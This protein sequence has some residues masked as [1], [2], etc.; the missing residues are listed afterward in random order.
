MMTAS[1]LPAP[2][3]RRYITLDHW[4]GLAC[5]VVLINHSVWAGRDSATWSDAER[6]IVAV[7]SELWLGVP[8]FFVI[9]GYCISAT[10]DAHRRREHNQLSSYMWRRVRRIFPPYWVVLAAVVLLVGVV[11]VVVPRYPLTIGSG[12]FLRPWW[13]SPAQ[14]LGNVTL[15]EQWRTNVTGGQK[16]WFLGHAWTLAYEE[17]FYLVAALLLWL[18]PRRFFAGAAGVSALVGVTTLLSQRHGWTIQ[19]FFL[20]GSWLQFYLGILVYYSLNYGSSRLR[21]VLVAS[22]GAI[23]GT[24]AWS[25][26]QVLSGGKAEAD[27]FFVALCFAMILVLLNRYDRQAANLRLLGPLHHA[28]M[29]CYSL[30]LVHLP[31]NKFVHVIMGA[32]SMTSSP[33]ATIPICAAASLSVA[34]SFHLLVERRFMAAT[35][36]RTAVSREAVVTA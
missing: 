30:Y 26:P 15:T 6:T 35:A 14:W 22:W 27:A 20:D 32:L 24:I 33:W 3:T 11:D 13:Y 9:S 23:A 1:E 18:V 10:V 7:A 36:V 8:M 2:R 34:W 16:A 31:V 21:M 4:R 29:M 28:G 5:L 19:G 17:Q 25:T 12:E